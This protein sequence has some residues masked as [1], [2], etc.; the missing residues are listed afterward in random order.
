MKHASILL[1]LFTA[2]SLTAC[3]KEIQNRSES[4][5]NSNESNATAAANDAG[6]V[7]T[8]SNSRIDNRI[9][10][11]DRASNGT[12]TLEGKYSTN[13]K[14][15]GLALGSQGAVILS[16][17]KQWLFAVNAGSNEISVFRINPNG[18][19]QFVDIASSH[20]VTPISLAAH[21]SLLYVLNAGAGFKG[22]IA[23]FHISSTGKLSYI[24]NSKRALSNI[25]VG[26]AQISF[27]N[28][29]TALAISEKATS[30]IVTFTVDANGLPGNKQ[31]MSSAGVE[32]FGFAVGQFGNIYVS[33]AF[34]G[35]VGKSTVSSYHLSN[36]GNVAVVDALVH[37]HQTAACWVVITHDN[38]YVYSANTGSNT[39][40]GYAVNSNGKLSLLNADG[41]TATTGLAPADEALSNDSKYLYVL[42][43]GDKTIGSYSI[44]ANGSLTKID[45]DGDLHPKSAGLAAR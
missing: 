26:P 41:V 1:G 34:S 16:E 25:A 38:K 40:T 13:G 18:T 8:E 45:E 39:I 10:H 19:L 5:A 24:E 11:Y 30:K 3:Q 43:G 21:G 42:N 7:Y 15:T 14:G 32:P 20:G 23:G 2:V 35:L 12:L 17:D 33:E 44:A 22:S 9:F 37:N 29:G 31:K 27:K 6:D 4:N 36:N 28:N